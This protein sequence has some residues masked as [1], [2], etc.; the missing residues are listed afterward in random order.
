MLGVPKLSLNEYK[1]I[2]GF[3][4][5]KARGEAWRGGRRA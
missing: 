4:A 1:L 5:G 3:F 2:C